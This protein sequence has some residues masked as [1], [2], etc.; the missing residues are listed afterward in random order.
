MSCIGGGCYDV[1]L[2]SPFRKE[3]LIPPA[4]SPQP[5]APFRILIRGLS[6]KRKASS[7]G[8]PTTNTGEENAHF[9]S[10]TVRDNIL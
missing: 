8:Q 7:M 4:D 5:S 9:L 1:P 3:A 6:C 2:R 10:C